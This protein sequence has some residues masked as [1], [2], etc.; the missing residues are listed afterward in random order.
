MGMQFIGWLLRSSGAFY[1]RRSFG[2][3][4]LYWAV[5]TE[6]VQTQ[7]CNGDSPIE[8]YVEGTRSRTSKSYTPKFGMSDMMYTVFI[9][10]SHESCHWAIHMLHFLAGVVL[11]VSCRSPSST[12]VHP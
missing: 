6:Y 10:V 12:R 1:I 11:L 5:F 2:D 9:V 8:F 7:I 3:D 4:H